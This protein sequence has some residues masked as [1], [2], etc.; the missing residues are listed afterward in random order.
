MRIIRNIIKF[1]AVEHE[2]S[3]IGEDINSDLSVIR[4]S[5]I[6]DTHYDSYDLGVEIFGDGEPDEVG[7]VMELYVDL[8]TLLIEEELFQ[9]INKN[10]IQS[11]FDS[12]LLNELIQRKVRVEWNNGDETGELIDIADPGEGFLLAMVR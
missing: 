12:D 11:L 2:F 7:P 3:D 10:K 1:D 9:G 5:L 8:D 6:R 4:I